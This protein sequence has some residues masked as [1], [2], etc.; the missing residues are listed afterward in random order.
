MSFLSHLRCWNVKS[1]VLFFTVFVL[2]TKRYDFI[3]CATMWLRP[4]YKK[5]HKHCYT[6]AH[7]LWFWCSSIKCH[8]YFFKMIF[9]LLI[10]TSW[11]REHFCF[12]HVLYYAHNKLGITVKSSRSL[13]LN[14]DSK[15]LFL[16]GNYT[17]TTIFASYT[18]KMGDRLT[19]PLKS[20]MLQGYIKLKCRVG[21][22]TT[23]HVLWMKL[24]LEHMV[25]RSFSKPTPLHRHTGR[26]SLKSI[27][28]HF[29]REERDSLSACV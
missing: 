8:I 28:T 29:K 7:K 15:G 13:P 19:F 10:N 24:R 20:L 18:F 26:Q 25:T 23:F 12:V 17:F 4:K 14:K 9:G 16:P 21:N 2:L 1:K 11:L 22:R 5:C 3:H 6:W 27:W